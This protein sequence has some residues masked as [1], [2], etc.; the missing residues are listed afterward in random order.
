M[1]LPSSET[2]IR[3]ALRAFDEWLEVRRRPGTRRLYTQILQRFATWLTATHPTLPPT[4]AQ[5][6]LRDGARYRE[7]LCTQ[8]PPKQPATINTAIAALE[9]WGAWL[10][11]AG[12]RTE[13]PFLAIQRIRTEETQRAP[14][15]LAPA[16]QDALLKATTMLRMPAR[17]SII[18]GLLLHTGLRV[19]ELCA[20]T[21][22]DI[23]VGERSGHLLVRN[24]KGG[25]A[26]TVPLNVEVRRMLWT[27]LVVSSPDG[28]S[29]ESRVQRSRWTSAHAATMSKWIA[30]HSTIPVI[31]S[32][33]GGP[34]QARAVQIVVG[35]A[36]YHARITDPPVTPHTLRH[37]YATQL[38][39][40]GAP[41]TVV[42]TLLGHR[43][44]TTTAIYTKPS[45]QELIRWTDT[46]ALE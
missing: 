45:A 31:A 10:V 1:E 16:Q 39:V 37:T 41:L 18:V 46:L 5:I 3:D 8:Q 35:T 11:T 34:L 20:L 28:A 6:G 42:A 19:A 15:A 33:K 32:Q 36:A 9:S 44:L 21:W 2:S 14:K 7:F 22:G 12:L 26:R 24:G 38:V 43:S 4:V 17:A 25:T 30:N 40:N 23:T 29:R 27:W 13:N